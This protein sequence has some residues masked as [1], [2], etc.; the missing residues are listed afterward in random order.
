MVAIIEAA[1]FLVFFLASSE[2]V[3]QC[4]LKTLKGIFMLKNIGLLFIAGSMAV[5]SP[6]ALAIEN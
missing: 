4:F 3:F 6:C 5:A 1:S 2:K